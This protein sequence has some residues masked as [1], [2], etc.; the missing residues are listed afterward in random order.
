M[1]KAVSTLG[2]KG[3]FNN[4]LIPPYNYSITSA[5]GITKGL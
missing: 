1:L 2:V 5:K 4:Y 3:L